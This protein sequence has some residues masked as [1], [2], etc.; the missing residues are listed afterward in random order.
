MHGPSSLIM[1]WAPGE[2]ARCP[3]AGTSRRLTQR[4]IPPCA[5]WM[6]RSPPL[7]GHIWARIRR[8]EHRAAEVLRKLRHF[9]GP[10]DQGTDVRRSDEHTSELQSLMRISYAVFCL[11]TKPPPNHTITQVT[12]SQSIC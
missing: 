1:G 5:A 12:N 3:L 4:S 10:S 2:R 6:Q 11:K 7:Y 8:L 9:T